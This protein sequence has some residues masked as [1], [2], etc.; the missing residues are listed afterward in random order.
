VN[1]RNDFFWTGA[2]KSLQSP[3]RVASLLAAAYLVVALRNAP[4]IRLVHEVS[5][6]NLFAILGRRSLEVFTLGAVLALIAE[7]LLWV[8]H[9]S[10]LAIPASPAAIAWEL[11]LCML[12]IWAMLQ[13]AKSDRFSVKR[14]EQFARGF[15]M[16]S[17]LRVQ[18]FATKN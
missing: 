8:V 17:S 3:L 15:R 5:A 9:A 2:S 12:A 14:I 6:N 13:I 4:L 7:R 1:M 10:G 18:A 16:R 11:A